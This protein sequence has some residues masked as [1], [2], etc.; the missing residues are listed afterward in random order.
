M[1]DQAADLHET[2]GGYEVRMRSLTRL[3]AIFFEKME[4][5]AITEGS[6]LQKPLPIKLR[7]IAWI[8]GIA[9]VILMKFW[10]DHHA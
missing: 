9:V 6:R 5:H 1:V 2:L 10:L 3:A 8:I 4:N 7:L